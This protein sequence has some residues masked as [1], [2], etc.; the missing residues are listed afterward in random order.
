MTENGDKDRGSQNKATVDEAALQERLFRLG[1]TLSSRK[2]KPSN[3]PD[4]GLGGN[5]PGLARGLALGTEFIGAILLGCAVGLGFDYL[6]GSRPLGLILF[7]V[8]GFA[9]GVLVV[10][11]G[12]ARLSAP[13]KGEDGSIAPDKGEKAE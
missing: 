6:V 7:L 9:A 4:F 13:Q 12:A 2:N 1:E 3:A 11:R 8:L 10:I 5:T